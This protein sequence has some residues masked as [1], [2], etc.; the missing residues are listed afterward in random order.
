MSRDR[1]TQCDP[2]PTSRSPRRRVG[3][4]DE[5]RERACKRDV[6]ARMASREPLN[7]KDLRGTLADMPCYLTRPSGLP[8]TNQP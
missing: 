8:L 1:S 3:A 7:Y 5:T 6:Q 2:P 4:L